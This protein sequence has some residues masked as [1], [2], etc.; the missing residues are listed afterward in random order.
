[1]R[2]EPAAF[3]VVVA[4]ELLDGE[5]TVHGGDD[6]VAVVGLE[7]LVNNNDVA[8]EHPCVVHAVARHTGVE[9]GVGVRGEFAGDVYALACAVSSGRGETGVDFLHKL[10]K[11]CVLV[12]L[13]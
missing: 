4:A 8:I 3:V 12:G 11:Q 13:G 5:L 6:D 10:K 2:Y 9:G 7:R 1:M